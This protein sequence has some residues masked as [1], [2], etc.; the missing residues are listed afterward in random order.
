MGSFRRTSRAK[1]CSH[2]SLPDKSIAQAAPG[3]NRLSRRFAADLVDAS[4]SL[5][6][7][8]EKVDHLPSVADP[9]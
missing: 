5:T 7:R 2:R 6:C 9:D 4:M 8:P 3:L 1:F